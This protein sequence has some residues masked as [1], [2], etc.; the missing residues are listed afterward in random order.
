LNLIAGSF[1]WPFRGAWRRSW[2]GGVLVVLFLP[3]LFVLL[4]GYSI[5]AT[6]AAGEDPTKGPPAWRLS[7]RLVADGAWT[8]LA[9]LLVALPFLVVFEPFAGW[10]YGTH[11][12]STGDPGQSL[13][14]A[15]VLA[16]LILALPLGI[17]LLLVMPDATA[18]F[19][20]SGQPR[21]L[22]DF[23]ASLRAVR[24]DFATWNLAAAAIVT[25]WAVGVACV[26]LL[27]AGIVPGI[28][29]AILVSAH[30]TAALH[31]KSSP[32]PAG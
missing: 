24:D 25:G 26:G 19:A 15:R 10:L 14:Y 28:F 11:V 27:C 18:R 23:A 16:F 13:F 29:Y 31:D 6:R 20:R 9:V 8:A 5:A 7:G 22:F 4:F 2:L 32:P 17:A 12:W 21:D 3:L 30:A 1:A